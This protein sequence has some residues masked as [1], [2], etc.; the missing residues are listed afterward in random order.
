MITNCSIL[1][2]ILG[3]LGPSTPYH[4]N[5]AFLIHQHGENDSREHATSEGVVGVDDGP[6]LAVASGQGSIEAWPEQPEEDGTWQQK[7]KKS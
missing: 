2:L 5:L 6:V 7:E 4:V 3:P 1:Q